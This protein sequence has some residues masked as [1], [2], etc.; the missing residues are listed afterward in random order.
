MVHAQASL[1]GIVLSSQIM[2]VSRFQNVPKAMILHRP[3]L[4]SFKK[5]NHRNN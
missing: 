3:I 2:T 4:A 1:V 5:V